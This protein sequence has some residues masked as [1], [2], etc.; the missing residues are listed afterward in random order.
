VIPD[1]KR[2]SA[3]GETKPQAEFGRKKAE[4]TGLRS[5]CKPCER[6]ANKRLYDANPAKAVATQIAWAKRNPAQVRAK[7]KAN[8]ERNKARYSEERKAAYQIKREAHLAAQRERY[9]TDP[10]YRKRLAAHWAK[11]YRKDPA[12][13]A[14][15]Q[16]RYRAEN[17]EKVRTHSHMHLAR[18]AKAP[19]KTTAA[20]WLETLEYF[21]HRCAYCL[22]HEAEVGKLAREHMDPLSRGGTNWP[23]NLVPSCKSC[24]SRKNNRTV[25]EFAGAIEVR[26]PLAA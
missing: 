2:C 3:C 21:D 1:Q 5:A 22:G 11:R 19:G 18:K 14:A 25:L 4:L 15:Y 24:N 6:T 23:D 7:A 12:A 17:P 9:A 20:E 16:A 8:Y 13:F 10:A 26:A